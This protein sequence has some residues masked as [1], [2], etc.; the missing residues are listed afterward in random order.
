[1]TMNWVWLESS[2]RTRVKRWM[3]ASSSGASTSSRSQKGLGR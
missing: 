2:R 1:M 3:F